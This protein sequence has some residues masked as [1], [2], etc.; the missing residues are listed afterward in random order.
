MI[1][2]TKLLNGWDVYG[3]GTNQSPS[4]DDWQLSANKGWDFNWNPPAD[5]LSKYRNPTSY[6]TTRWATGDDPAQANIKQDW[7]GSPSWAGSTPEGEGSVYHP[8]YGWQDYEDVAGKYREAT[9]PVTWD[10][11]SNWGLTPNFT[12]PGFYEGGND[13]GWNGNDDTFYP[14]PGGTDA[15]TADVVPYQDYTGSYADLGTQYPYE[16]GTASDVLQNMATHGY[17][18]EQPDAWKWNESD[19]NQIIGG[20]GMPTSY[21]PAYQ[22]SKK[23]AQ[24]EIEDA[25][26]EAM[27]T[28]GMEGL[29]YSTPA[30]WKG[31]DIASRRMAELGSTWTTQE[32]GAQ[33]TAMSRMMDALQQRQTL[34]G[35]QAGLTEAAKGRALTAAGELPGLGSLY[36]QL[37]IQLAN[38]AA[39]LGGN[40]YGMSQADLDTQYKEAMRLAA[41][42]NPWLSMALGMSSTP[43]Q[44]QQYTPGCLGG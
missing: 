19:L 10:Q 1:D 27:E 42:N 26:K 6:T 31:Q 34:G 13:G 33:E 39:G 17:A 24:T 12:F 41:E 2:M 38:T 40:M 37:P 4:S 28:M 8:Y 25:I 15:R 3:N 7:W 23:V 18:T 20:M 35:A 44:P 36:A 32:L 43:G 11:F 30:I 16:W 21:A 5:W 9:G 22:A 29:R 14:P